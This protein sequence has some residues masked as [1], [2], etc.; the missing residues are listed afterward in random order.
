MTI[1]SYRN[2][3]VSA[4]IPEG[5]QDKKVIPAPNLDNI[6]DE[7]KIPEVRRWVLWKLTE[8]LDKKGKTVLRKLPYQGKSGYLAKA[9]DPKTWCSYDEALKA[10]QDKITL[11]YTEKGKAPVKLQG[12]PDGIGFELGFEKNTGKNYFG[13]DLD[14][15]LTPEKWKWATEIIKALDSYTEISPSGKGV[16]IL[17]IGT[18]SP[19]QTGT[20]CRKLGVEVYDKTHYFT[21]TGNHFEG[22]P[23]TLNNREEELRA[24]HASV[25]KPQGNLGE[26]NHKEKGERREK[27]KGGIPTERRPPISFSLVAPLTDEEIKEKL[28]REKGA[29]GDKAR[30]LYLYGL[31]Q[32]HFPDDS[33]DG[34]DWSGADQSLMNKIEFY[35]I[36]PSDEENALQLDRIFSGSALAKREKWTRAGYAENSYRQAT[37]RKA[38]AHGKEPG[39][40][41]W[42]PGYGKR[43]G[44]K[45]GV[46][47]GA[48]IIASLA[49]KI[50]EKY[51]LRTVKENGI[52]L[53]LEDGGGW[54]EFTEREL[55]AVIENMGGDKVKNSIV[56][57]VIGKIKRHNLISIQ[58][59]ERRPDLFMDA[60]GKVFSSITREVVDISEQKDVMVIH[61]IAAVF[62]PSAPVP[63][64]WLEVV[65]LIIPDELERLSLQEHIGSGFLR[66]M[67]YDKALVIVGDTRNGKTTLIEVIE[68][69]AGEDN[70][71]WVPLQ[72]MAK[73]FRPYKMWRKLFNFSDDLSK[74]A[75]RNSSQFKIQLGGAKITLEKK[76]GDDFDALVYATSVYAANLLAPAKDKDDDGYYSKFLLIKAPHT[77]ILPGEVA[78]EG[79]RDGEYNADPDLVE[80]LTSDPRKLSGI[81]NWALDGLARLRKQKGYSLKMTLEEGKL[82]Y[83]AMAAP[84]GD[85]EECMKMIC[86]REDTSLEMRKADLLMIYTTYCKARKIPKPT[87]KDFNKSLRLIGYNPDIRNPKYDTPASVDKDDEKKASPYILRGLSLRSDWRE[88]FSMWQEIIHQTQKTPEKAKIEV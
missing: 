36:S 22:S 26:E 65:E 75:I 40:K 77:F 71:S 58:D 34:G 80:K 67:K 47:R 59:F 73:P 33:E 27:E 87:R 79:L 60:S 8:V 16:H 53:R 23:F 63:P 25:W 55:A 2:L 44:S 56:A 35:C 11:T 74:E 42:S 81:L 14:G 3:S 66:E 82:R 38:I 83:D 78:P 18:K 48:N 9:N 64:E 57:D 15:L 70:V 24:F 76:Y 86:Y 45:K 5:P 51:T 39:A 7:I 32:L 17:G 29:A 31:Y 10:Y 19:G 50:L 43:V 49:K 20:N 54:K 37:I 12:G 69:V 28:L 84:V 1:E 21:A 85:L 72:D 30:D 61:K 4:T 41:H 46:G 52:I 88:T 6:P 62:D 68:A 13:I